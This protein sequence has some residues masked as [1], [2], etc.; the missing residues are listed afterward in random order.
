MSKTIKIY[1]ERNTGTNYLESLCKLNL[2]CHI[3]D[4]NLPGTIRI[5]INFIRRIGLLFGSP[6]LGE[7]LRDYYFK[8]Y[9]KGS[10]GWKHKYLS[11]DKGERIFP[12][13]LYYLIVVRHPLP[14][15]LSMYKRPYELG[16]NSK[17]IK[18]SEFIHTKC[19]VVSRECSPFLI[20]DNPIAV[21]NIKVRASL[22]FSKNRNSLIVKHE[23]LVLNPRKALE[24]ISKASGISLIGTFQD[25]NQSTKR[26]GRTTQEFR[27][28]VNQAEWL[29]KYQR[30]DLDYVYSNIDKDLA[31]ELGYN[32]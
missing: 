16:I 20:Y 14:W 9:M 18:F 3:I 5:P 17:K 6:S 22:E 2:K 23:E 24:D 8:N 29:K 27:A 4:S 32:F 19:K 12:S 11:I 7:S 25:Y 31:T 15:L 13:S 10:Y 21:W 28:A 30:S 1:G 26:D